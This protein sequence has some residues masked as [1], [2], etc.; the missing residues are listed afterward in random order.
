MKQVSYIA[1][2]MLLVSSCHSQAD[3]TK[4]VKVGGGCEGCEAI[5]EYGD[6]ELLTVDTLPNFQET[7][8]KLKIS[9]T[10]FQ[11]DGKTPAENVIIY[12]YHTN[13]DGLYEMKG[14]E[15]GWAKRHG[16]IRGWVKTGK[17]GKYTFYTFRPAAYPNEPVQEHIHMTIKEPKFNK[18]YIDEIVFDDDPLLTDNERKKLLN[19][20]G[21]GIVVPKMINGIWIVE[22]D[23]VL[24]LNIPD[25]P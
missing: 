21:S 15:E 25:Y 1:I 10:V 2:L 7:E 16:Y 9:G 3:K 5:F 20:C 23:I 19:R 18:Y 22:R 13:R 17:D 4:D 6:K 14:D 8:P 12:I 24:G 11:K